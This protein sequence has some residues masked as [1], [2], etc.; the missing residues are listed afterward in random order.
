MRFIGSDLSAWTMSIHEHVFVEEADAVAIDFHRV[1]G[2]RIDQR[3]KV[4]AE[5]IGDELVG[6]AIEVP[7]EA[8]HGKGVGFDR[9]SGFSL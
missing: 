2:V 9:F 3:G 7:G 5:F 6:T 4:V 8:A 1:P